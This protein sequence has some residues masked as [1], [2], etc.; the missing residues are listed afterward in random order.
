MAASAICLRYNCGVLVSNAPQTNL[1]LACISHCF[2]EHR[3]DF[4]HYL[5][6]CLHPTPLMFCAAD[7]QLIGRSLDRNDAPLVE[8]L[9]DREIS[10]LMIIS[11]YVGK[12]SV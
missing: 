10:S 8:F 9:A 11:S 1:N 6:F 12:K 5:M 7:Q 2:L 3:I 4:S